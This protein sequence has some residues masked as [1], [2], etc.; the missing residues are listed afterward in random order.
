MP[1]PEWD[2]LA[3]TTDP[4]HP[5]EL[6]NS[7]WDV[8]VFE[9]RF[10]AL[11]PA[12]PAAPRSIVP[13]APATG[14]CEVV[15]FTRDATGSLGGL[16]LWHLELLLQVWA[17]RRAEIGAR[18]DVAYVMPFENRGAEVG[19]TL[20]HPH[21]QLYAYPFVPPV[22][23]Q[24]LA[25]QQQHLDAHG[26][27]LLEE[28]VAAE[29]RDGRRLLFAGQHVAAFVPAC[30]RHPYEVWLAP[31]RAAP[32]LGALDAAERAEVARALKTVLLKYDGLFGRPLPYVMVWHEAPTDGRPHPEAHVHAEF[33][34][35]LRD[36][37]RLKYL[38]G[39]ELGAGMYTVDALPEDSAAELA[40]VPVEVGTA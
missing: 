28:H 4:T 36:A 18:R 31:R 7:A 6:P 27:G 2:P 39:T 34:T 30:A 35:P 38:A 5:T 15:V 12:A 24:E 37:K 32:H 21:G 17:D 40:A 14:V 13:T 22:P 20:P 11:H 1:P 16:P 33:Y 19:A 23:A 25:A 10:P 3:P 29:L 8:A 26:R 9:N